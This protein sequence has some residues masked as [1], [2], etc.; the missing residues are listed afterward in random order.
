MFVPRQ[1][2][3]S[4][5]RGKSAIWARRSKLTTRC[6]SF[7]CYSGSSRRASTV[8][9]A[10]AGSTSS[11]RSPRLPTSP[12]APAASS[13]REAGGVDPGVWATCS[14][15]HRQQHAHEDEI[16]QLIARVEHPGGDRLLREHVR[17]EP[18]RGGED[19]ENVDV[20][21]RHE[22]SLRSG[23]SYDGS[24]RSPA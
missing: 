1:Q 7:L 18:D 4:C 17:G 22:R 21:G 15:P 12:G 5:T 6:S 13:V 19:G 3:T 8:T 24:A 2:N 14:A 11:S 10:Y 9:R 16:R 20:G 23:L